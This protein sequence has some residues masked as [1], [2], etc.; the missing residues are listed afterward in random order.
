VQRLLFNN[1]LPLICNK[2]SIRL[3]L[4]ITKPDL[5]HHCTMELARDLDQR[6]RSKPSEDFR[7]WSAPACDYRWRAPF[8]TTF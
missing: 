1:V 8:T 4:V 2:Y 3:K 7:G 5:E 6:R